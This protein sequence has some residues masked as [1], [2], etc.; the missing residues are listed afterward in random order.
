MFIRVARITR[1]LDTP[2]VNVVGNEVR[3]FTDADKEVSDVVG[4]VVDAFLP[5]PKAA[6]ALYAQADALVLQAFADVQKRT[7]RDVNGIGY[8]AS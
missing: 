5:V 3:T 1:H 8:S 6:L 7:V 4:D 2:N